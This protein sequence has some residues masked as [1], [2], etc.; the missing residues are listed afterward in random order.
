MPGSILWRAEDAYPKQIWRLSDRR[1]ESRVDWLFSH[2]G[3]LYDGAAIL[4]WGSI[5][6]DEHRGRRY[7]PNDLGPTYGGQL[8]AGANASRLITFDANNREN[9]P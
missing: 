6:R 3:M 8:V 7:Y 1:S 9:E 2:G 5:L 4:G